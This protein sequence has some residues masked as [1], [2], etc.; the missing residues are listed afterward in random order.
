MK[1][2]RFTVIPNLPY[3]GRPRLRQQLDVYLPEPAPREALPL[4]VIVHGGG[5]RGGDKGAPGGETWFLE[6]GFAL[7]RVNYRYSTEAAHPAQLEDCREA[8]RY[9]KRHAMELGIDPRRVMAIGH[10]AGGHLVSLL[11][12][13]ARE[14][15][16]TEPAAVVN[17]AGPTDFM[18]L[19]GTR[20]TAPPKDPEGDPMSLAEGLLGHKLDEKP[21]RTRLASPI[22]WVDAAHR[23]CPQLLIY[24][25]ADEIVPPSQ[26]ERFHEV[27]RRHGARSVLRVIPGAGHVDPRFWQEEN[28]GR[29][30]EFF[31]G[32]A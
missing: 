10:S 25:G 8:I 18:E 19:A 29:I 9:L 16:G 1:F 26:G 31:Q 23:P 20:E 2:P 24:G 12:C 5:W 11:A 4:I 32:V 13:T 3:T 28:Y 15:P 21:E 6:R 17:Q 22:A 30:L 14:A 7:A 27:L